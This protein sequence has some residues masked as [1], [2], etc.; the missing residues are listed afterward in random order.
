MTHTIVA[1]D[2]IALLVF[3]LIGVSRLIT[4]WTDR[5]FWLIGFLGLITE[6]G[7][8]EG[9]A[10]ADRGQTDDSHDWGLDH[11]RPQH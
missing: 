10:N 4:G 11:N 2:T 8:G 1:A 5:A 3:A 6:T 9:Q 7:A